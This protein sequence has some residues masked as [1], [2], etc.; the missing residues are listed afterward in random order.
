MGLD[1]YLV[2]KTYVG[3]YF[4]EKA[5]MVKV[6][7]PKSRS[8]YIKEIK[9]ERISEIVERVA[10][11]RKANA[12]HKWFVD[13]VQKGEDDCGEYYVSNEDLKKLLEIVDKVL[14]ASKL[15]GGNIVDGQTATKNGWKDN[16]VK[17][18]II[19]DSTVAKR[20]LPCAGGFFFGSTDYNEYYYQD[21][22]ETKKM[23]TPLLKEDGEYYYSASW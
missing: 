2:K 1:M 16:V 22:V 19:E 18:K 23:L 21:L 17:G 5:E 4:K 3:N 15:V 7:V 14:A 9:A 12:I 13:N 10:C 20:L 8:S 11:W 6:V